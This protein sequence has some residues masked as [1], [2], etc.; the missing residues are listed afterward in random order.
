[1]I[2]HIWEIMKWLYNYVSHII[3]SDPGLFLC[4]VTQSY[5]ATRLCDNLQLFNTLV[6]HTNPSLQSTDI[7]CVILHKHQY[8]LITVAM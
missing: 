5:N 6:D 7:Q 4:M 8:N 1:M 3:R 2:R